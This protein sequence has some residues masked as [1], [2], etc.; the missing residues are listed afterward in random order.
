MKIALTGV[1]EITGKDGREWVRLSG[2]AKSGKAVKAFM[3]SEKFRVD[4]SIAPSE[5][6]IL[7]SMSV[8]PTINV[9]FDEDGRVDEVTD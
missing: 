1:E 4:P 8:L 9:E 3:P 7:E 5:D 2:F 6:V